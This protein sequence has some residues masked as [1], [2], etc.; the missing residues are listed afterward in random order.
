[1]RAET[2]QARP[3]TIP[4]AP[5]V[6]LSPHVLDLF[7]KQSRCPVTAARF[8]F[9]DWRGDLDDSGIEV[10]RATRGELERAA[11]AR[12]HLPPNESLRR[13]ENRFRAPPHVV[14][15]KRKFRLQTDDWPRRRNI[16][17]RSSFG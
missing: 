15:E 8:Q 10:D 3:A 11:R 16:S 2:L 17:R 9:D 12:K 4:R 7:P 1:M 14:E 13:S 6:E 5:V